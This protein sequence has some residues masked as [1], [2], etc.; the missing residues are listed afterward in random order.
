M[1]GLQI[2]KASALRNGLNQSRTKDGSIL[3][4]RG[5][6][7]RR[8]VL[9]LY[10]IVPTAFLALT[11]IGSRNVPATSAIAIRPKSLSDAEIAVL[12]PRNW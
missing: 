3:R 11:N 1:A 4:T 8:E 9:F 5:D 12:N 2:A 10:A 7:D 6:H